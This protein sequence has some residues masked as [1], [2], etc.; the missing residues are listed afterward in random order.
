MGQS[1]LIPH[2]FRTEYRKIVSVLCARFGFGQM[3]VAEDIASETFLTAVQTWPLNGLP[4]HPVAWLYH[5]AKNK[6]RN[7]LQREA[8][9][10]G[11][12]VP[13]LRGSEAGPD[14]NE[15]DLSPANIED[16]QLRMM[17]AICHPSIAA[18]A[19]IGLSLRILCGFGIEEIADAFLTSKE[20]ISKRLYRAKEKLREGKA[21]IGLLNAPAVEERLP[22]VLT[23]IYLLFTEGYYSMPRDGVASAEPSAAKGMRSELCHEAMRLGRMLI[24][25]P[26]T[27]QPAVSALLALMCFHA[28]RL[29]AR[30]DQHGELVLYADQDISRWNAGL[31]SEGV[32][33]LRRSASGPVLT[34]YHLEANIAYWNCVK[35]DNVEKWGNILQ[36]YNHLL[37][38][39]YSPV[40][41]LNR[42][43]AVARTLGKAAALEQA[44]RLKLTGNPYYWALLGELYT[45]IDNR[46]ARECYQEAVSLAKSEAERVALVKKIDGLWNGV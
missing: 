15:I 32:Y 16:S 44:E 8:V 27:D 45:G 28:S 3:E 33:Y 2:L 42:T 40:A 1:E 12:I 31:I 25:Y 18:E 5:V 14:D 4:P 41:A 37:Q 20:T 39:E 10:R 46:R 30:V 23:T 13:A 26:L 35:E 6:A 43:Y 7:Y 29:D 34:K 9:F 17:F 19:Q 36:L 24:D 21:D 38:L 22:A 11:T